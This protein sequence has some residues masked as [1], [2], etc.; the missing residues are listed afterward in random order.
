MDLKQNKGIGMTDAIIAVVILVIF[1]GIIV[2][3]SYNIYIQSNFIKR[4]EQATSY[5]VEVIEYAQ[6]CSY[7]DVDTQVLIDY[8]SNKYDN[9]NVLEGE[10]NQGEPDYEGYTI[11]INVTD[12]YPNYAK[13]LN[14][15]TLY[16]LGNKYRNVNMKTLIY[17]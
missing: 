9:V 16:K 4:N 12:E 3:I 1:T 8:I 10:Y 2:S 6:A 5:N 7:K 13:Q 17:K 14:I 11:F 15:T